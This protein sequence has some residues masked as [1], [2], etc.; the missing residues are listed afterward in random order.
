MPLWR[1]ATAATCIATA[2]VAG[3]GLTA[4]LAAAVPSL[5]S[6]LLAALDTTIVHG[7]L[8]AVVWASAVWYAEG[9]VLMNQC[10]YAHVECVRQIS[11]RFNVCIGRPPRQRSDAAGELGGD[12]GACRDDDDH[13]KSCPAL[14]PAAAPAAASGW[15]SGFVLSTVLCFALAIAL[16]ADHFIAARSFSLSAAMRLPSRPFGHTLA[17]LFAA[18]A[19]V[20]GAAALSPCATRYAG[21]S[22]QWALPPTLLLVSWL[23]HQLRDGT[24]RG[25]TVWP[26]G[27]STA[28]LSYVVYLAA[29]VGTALAASAVMTRAAQIGG[30]QPTTSAMFPGAA[31]PV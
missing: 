27:P 6:N 24:R 5:S 29:M 7:S 16:D 13:A 30:K 8:A 4:L 22:V 9:A 18:T 15:R 23:T 25:L 19:A 14:P 2:C 10:V 31:E 11:R 12:A 20:G 21:G 3:D 26:G 17:F 1:L 28:P